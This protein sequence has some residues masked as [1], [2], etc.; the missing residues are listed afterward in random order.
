[1][2]DFPTT[3]DEAI[4][5]ARTATQA[6]LAAGYTRLQVE[7]LLPELKLMEPAWQFLPALAEW[8]DRLVI[9]F[10]DAGA[11]ALARRDWEGISHP[12][13]SLDVA[14]SR[15]TTSV[16]ELVR[17]ED[18]IFLCVGPS[19]V[20]IAP[21]EQICQAAGDRPVVLF[22]PQL[23]DVSIVGI[24]YTARKLRDRF[25][26]TFEPSYY[27]RPFE[28]AALLRCYPSPWQVYLETDEGYTVVGEEL[29]KPNAEKLDE[30]LMKATGT[31]PNSGGF[32]SEL[33]RFLKAL[34]Q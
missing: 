13:R 24:G 17:P 15:Q 29:L 32:L 19:S 30:I 10:T 28:G 16:E 1:M 33:Q 34:G 8:G 3:L 4:A 31:Q 23:E 5:Q 26:N 14:G 22:N 21:V 25:L 12:I 20:E 9:F 2:V 7:L 18:E 11:A 27:L 6:A